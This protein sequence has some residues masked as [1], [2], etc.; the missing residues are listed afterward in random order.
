M[1][2]KD[3]LRAEVPPSRLKANAWVAGVGTVTFLMTIRPRSVLANLQMTVSP[4]DTS[5]LSIGLPSSQAA[6]LWS[7]PSGTVSAAA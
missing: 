5:M 3:W 6:E 2:E 7:H 4:G 1:S